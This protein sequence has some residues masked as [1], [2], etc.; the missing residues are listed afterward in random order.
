MLQRRLMKYCFVFMKQVI[1]YT[2]KKLF[3]YMRE[4]EL[5]FKHEVPNPYQISVKHTFF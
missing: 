4:A 5:K 3:I 1:Y 2:A